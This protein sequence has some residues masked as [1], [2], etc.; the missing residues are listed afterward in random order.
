MTTTAC[1]YCGGPIPRGPRPRHYCCARCRRQYQDARRRDERAEARLLK[2]E[3]ARPFVDPWSRHDLDDYTEEEIWANALMG[4]APVVL[5]GDR[6]ETMAKRT[7]PPPTRPKPRPV[8]WLSML[9]AP[10]EEKS[11]PKQGRGWKKS[12]LTLC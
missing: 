12:W 4:A 8:Q 7:A 10:A 6:E 5:P 9:D 11:K 2:E 1:R 3:L